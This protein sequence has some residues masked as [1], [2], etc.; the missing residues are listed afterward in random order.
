MQQRVLFQKSHTPFS[1]VA[2]GCVDDATERQIVLV[3]DHPQ[4]T[5][6]ILNFHAVVK[7]HTAVD[8]VRYFFF[9]KDLF[10]RPGHVMGP[11]QQGHISIRHT[12]SVQPAY[13]FAD[14]LRF[15]F[16]CVRKVTHHRLAVRQSG[17]QFFRY[18]F[19][20]FVNEG[21]GCCQDFRSRT[22]VLRHK[23]GAGSRK[24]LLKIQQ[25]RA[26]GTPPCVD[27]LIRIPNHKQV[28]MIRAQNFHQFILQGINILEFIN[29]N[30]FQPL[31]PFLP[32]V[33]MLLKDIQGKFD[34]VVVVQPE[35][36]LFLIQV[37]VK[38][39]I[40]RFCC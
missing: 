32:D 14:P 15:R 26:V 13:L 19:G 24:A 7:L 2:F 3:G 27:G 33:P 37:T 11:I 9:Q 4:V 17:N 38:D 28:L 40:F 25:I 22:V 23:D 31:L 29:H 5:E 36:L 6:G 10:H 18:A 16:L 34:Q 20:I 1:H 30:V 8:G 39:Y 12:A 35:A 21:I